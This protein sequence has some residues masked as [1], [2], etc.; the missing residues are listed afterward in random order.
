MPMTD[1]EASLENRI[2]HLARH[3]YEV[4]VGRCG[5]YTP[6]SREGWAGT[7]MPWRALIF[8]GAIAFPEAYGATATL[9]L[10]AAVGA[11]RRCGEP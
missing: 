6:P 4:E 7:G 10:E 1:Q 2:E 3:G 11:A 8:R 9:A 5:D